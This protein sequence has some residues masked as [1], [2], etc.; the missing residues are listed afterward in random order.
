MAD[1]FVNDTM[2]GFLFC[3]YLN[4]LRLVNVASFNVVNFFVAF[5]I[6]KM[7]GNGFL[8]SIA[9]K[10]LV[11]GTVIIHAGQFLVFY[12]PFDYP[13]RGNFWR[14]GEEKFEY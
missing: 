12:L 2:W 14:T 9:Y 13:M 1:N 8:S 11:R 6:S 7:A 5:P 4:D 3:G 10:L